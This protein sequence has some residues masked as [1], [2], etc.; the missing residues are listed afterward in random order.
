M[1][2][3]KPCPFCNNHNFTELFSEATAAKRINYF[4]FCGN[5]Q[6]QGPKSRDSESAIFEW[7]LTDISQEAERLRGENVI[8][9]DALEEALKELYRVS[10]SQ[11]APIV[12]A[13]L[14][15]ARG[16]ITKTKDAMEDRR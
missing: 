14:A 10:P 12:R 9:L 1:S 11:A 15:K 13:A 2:E 7:D 16:Q 3:I 5:C 6:A 4:V 8:M